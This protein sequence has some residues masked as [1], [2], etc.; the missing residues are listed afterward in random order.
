VL[1][2]NSFIRDREAEIGDLWTI[3]ARF[4]FA[5]GKMLF[6]GKAGYANTKLN[7]DNIV[8]NDG[9]LFQ[10]AYAPGTSVGSYGDRLGGYFL[11]LGAEYM[12]TGNIVSG[13]DYTFS[14]FSADRIFRNACCGNERINVDL[15]TVMARVSYKFGAPERPVVAR[16]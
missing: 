9:G 11:G 5:A 12:I 7:F 10:A 6:Y 13:V 4:G 8:V 1:T 16:Y 2:G 15:H 3:G 14:Q